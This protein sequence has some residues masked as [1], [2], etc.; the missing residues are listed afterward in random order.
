MFKLKRQILNYGVAIA[1]VAIAALLMLWLDPY[2]YFNKAS[3][4]LF[5]GAVTV[6]AWYGG[7]GPGL[8][9]TLL[10]ALVTNYLFLEPLLSA[11]LT[12]PAA[13]RMALFV[14]QGGLISMLVG[15]LRIA[16]RRTKE[17]LRQLEASEGKF[18][19]LADSNVVGVVTGDIYGAITDA[20]DAFLSS[21]GYSRQ[22]LLAGRLRW[23][24]MTPA[25]LKPLD[26]DALQELMTQGKSV[27]YE[28]AFI[29][30]QGHRVPVMV[31]SAL[32][33]DNPEQIISFILDVSERKRAEQRLAVQYAVARALAE[34]ATVSEAILL[35]L[36]SLGES[37]GWEVSF[38][39]QLNPQTGTLRY[40]QGWHV[41]DRDVTALVRGNQQTTFAP[42]VGLPGQIWQQGESAWIANLAEAANFPRR[43]IALEVDL[44]SVFGFPVSIHHEILG[45]IECFSSRYQEPDAD[46]LNLMGAIG[47]QIGQFLDR[48]Q[49]EEELQVSQSLFENFMNY[50]PVNAFIKDAS[51]RYLYVN[52]RVE[53]AFN[54]PLADW[55]GKTDFDLFPYETALA[56]RAN[57]LAVFQAGQ[58]AQV[59]ESAPSDQGEIHYLSFKFPLKDAE[60]NPL[61]AGMSVDISDR[62]RFE[63]ER[64]QLLQQLETSLGQLEAVINSMTEGLMIADG[65]GQILQFNPAALALHGYEN[66]AQVQHHLHAFHQVFESR[67]YQGNL[68]PLEQ[69]PLARAIRG[70]TFS[71]WEA[72]IK[73][74]DTGKTWIGSYSGT[75]VRSK[76][77]D[78]VLAIVTTHDVTE[79]RQAQAAIARS[80]A[81]EK[82]V[83]AEAESANRIKDEFLAV[84]SHELRTPLN[85]ILG[86]ITLLRQGK[87]DAQK[88]VHALETIERNTKLQSQ[89]IDDLLDISRILRGK[90]TLNLGTVNLV[91]IIRA[92]LETVRLAAEAKTIELST[93]LESAQKTVTGD[94]NRLQQVVWN[95][96][97]NAV[98]FTPPGGK[99]TIRLAYID[100]VAR[101][102]VQD[103]GQGIT[104]EFLP[105]MFDY[106]R[107]ADSSTTRK[108]GGLGLGLAIARQ[109]VELHGGTIT[110]H[111]SGQGQGATFTV[112]LPIQMQPVVAAPQGDPDSAAVATTAPPPLDGLHVLAVDDEADNLNL[113]QFILEEAGARVTVC[114]SAR[115]ALTQ[116]VQ[117]QPDILVTDIGMPD[118]DGYALL[119]RV[120]E[121]SAGDPTPGHRPMPK[122][123]A[124]T[125]YASDLD[126]QKILQ[127]GF[128]RHL[129][130]PIEP[131]QLV[132]AIAELQ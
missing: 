6:S 7:R 21:V 39:W 9:A 81:T 17:S 40:C 24:E 30:K 99:I 37:L 45:V 55:T 14:L 115:E 59:S 129:A 61:L 84:L 128:Q 66:L 82:A 4:L 29:G 71:N 43:A 106:F 63:A 16:Q 19:R 79:Q 127:A 111:S 41:P 104:P 91:V 62:K 10:S 2:A 53:Q 77:G 113:V 33:E 73:R 87:L 5:F 85:P 67:D 1:S 51:G 110:A 3:F 121:W 132:G 49:T 116:M 123:I 25:D 98:K 100:Q 109:I 50:S 95:L 18:R 94:F 78:T 89:L 70:E 76:Q 83:R 20:N 93:E 12:L 22:D 97:S 8:V 15:S 54:R 52:P 48:K 125:A 27:P 46:L 86:W 57:D 114:T 11:T 75:P 42:G 92:A 35:V 47:S 69:W 44:H 126:Q 101:I 102:Q 80:L 60:G 119:Q 112:T 65:Q 130:K 90:L 26:V 72:Q 103:T 107:Q 13:I 96:L 108:F 38:F 88:T 105:V 32:L 131:Q 68:V 31:G 36:Q 64:E 58:L 117:D 23:T 74:L 34:A 124:L 120:R 122:A 118:M 56:V 28:K